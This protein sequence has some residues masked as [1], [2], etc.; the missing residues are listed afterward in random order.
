MFNHRQ[1]YIMVQLFCHLLSCLRFDKLRNY[2]PDE[3]N[4]PTKND[5]HSLGN[6]K[7]YCSN[8]ESEGTGCKTYLDKINGGCLWLFKQNIINNIDSLSKDQSKVFII[9]IMLWLNY[10]LNLKKDEKIKNLNGFYTKYIEN[11]THYTNCKKNDNDCSN[12]LKDKTGYNNFKEFIE[13]NKHLM[14]INIE[15]LS[16]FYDA[17]KLLCNMYTELDANDPKCEKCLENAR[18]FVEKYEKINASDISE[19]SPYYQ[20]L[21]TLSN[22]YNNF[23]NYCSANHVDCSDIPLLSPINTTKKKLQ[24]SELSFEDTS[25]SLSIVNKLFIVLSIFGAIAIFFGISYKYS[26]FGFRKQAQRQHLR[27]KLKK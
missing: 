23:K 16:K 10:M 7:D 12:L 27:E 17:S 18:K 13:K 14:N 5:I 25:S 1:L 2:F 19:D 9:Y 26:L 4:K 24:I 6:I 3:L 11:N 21:S 22:E 8:G 15:D 20:I